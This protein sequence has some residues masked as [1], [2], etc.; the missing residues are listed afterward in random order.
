MKYKTGCRVEPRGVLQMHLEREITEGTQGS[1]SP[2]KPWRTSQILPE[3]VGA[4]GGRQRGR[5]QDTRCRKC[6]EQRYENI[7][8]TAPFENPP[9]WPEWKWQYWSW[10]AGSHHAQHGGRESQAKESGLYVVTSAESPDFWTG[11]WHTQAP[12]LGNK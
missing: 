2:V 7:N 5:R 3:S 1:G 11:V 4:L 8:R 12:G 6:N 10:R 9:V